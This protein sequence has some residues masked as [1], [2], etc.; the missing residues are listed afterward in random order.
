MSH[1]C[2]SCALEKVP[3]T[4]GETNNPPKGKAGLFGISLWVSALVFTLARRLLVVLALVSSMY[5]NF[6][7]LWG[8]L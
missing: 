2:S 3:E 5:F 8:A 4:S 7:I 1:V 6:S